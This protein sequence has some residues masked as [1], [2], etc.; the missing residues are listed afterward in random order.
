MTIEMRVGRPKIKDRKLL[1]AHVLSVRVNH[2]ER[3][4]LKKAAKLYGWTVPEF[5]KNVSL[6]MV[7]KA[8]AK[9]AKS[10][11]RII[12]LSPR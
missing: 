4:N 7:D 5:I 2:K 1:K 8:L 11:N 3:D 12:T 9:E 10:E 6:A